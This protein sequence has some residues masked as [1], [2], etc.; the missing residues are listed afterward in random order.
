MVDGDLYLKRAIVM[1]DCGVGKM[2]RE[3]ICIVL[4]APSH[5]GAQKQDYSQL[6]PHEVDVKE[7]RSVNATRDTKRACAYFRMGND[8]DDVQDE[9][10]AGLLDDSR[11]LQN[12][13]NLIAAD[14]A[15]SAITVT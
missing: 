6:E 13:Q 15:D 8:L 14:E 12:R 4:A 11:I 1:I 9:D 2:T 5:G 3:K 7:P 10:R